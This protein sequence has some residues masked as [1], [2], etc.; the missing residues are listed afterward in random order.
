MFV[1]NSYWQIA[2]V[3]KVLCAPHTHTFKM[4]IDFGFCVGREAAGMNQR[5]VWM[6]E[7]MLH[8]LGCGQALQNAT[9]HR[10]STVS[11]RTQNSQ[12]MQFISGSAIFFLLPVHSKIIVLLYDCTTLNI[13]KHT[14]TVSICLGGLH[15]DSAGISRIYYNMCVWVSA[16]QRMVHIYTHERIKQNVMTLTSIYMHSI[17]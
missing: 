15:L 9:W 5:N 12:C 11:V 3:H 13:H 6:N 7:L 10:L 17:T 1:G 2:A 8:A 14:L 16:C 4:E